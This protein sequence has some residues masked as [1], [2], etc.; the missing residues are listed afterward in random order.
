MEM[1]RRRGRGR[2]REKYRRRRSGRIMWTGERGGVRRQEEDQRF[3]LYVAIRFD[4]GWVLWN[5]GKE[6]GV[7]KE[8]RCR[9][10]NNY[11]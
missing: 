7:G 4:G 10:G 11:Q 2:G 8:T 6:K 1:G 3:V 9:G 5:E